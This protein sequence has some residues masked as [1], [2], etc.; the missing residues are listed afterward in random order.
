MTII[1]ITIGLAIVPLPILL[2]D[3]PVFN[4]EYYTEASKQ[5]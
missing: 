1:A 3:K 4:D 5:K 2:M